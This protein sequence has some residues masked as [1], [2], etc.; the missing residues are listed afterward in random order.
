MP[1][2]V[3]NM[4]QSR[5]DEQGYINVAASNPA[6]PFKAGD[7]V[8]LHDGSLK[9]LEGVFLEMRGQD[10][11]MVLLDWIQKRMRVETRTDNLSIVKRTKL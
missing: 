4:L 10:R 8:C 6:S 9:G 11:A 3:I 5:H 2:A 7:A 1:D